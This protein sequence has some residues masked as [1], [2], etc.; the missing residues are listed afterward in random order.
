MTKAA[1]KSAAIATTAPSTTALAV[2]TRDEIAHLDGLD[3]VDDGLSELS[4]E[5][6]RIAAK[7]WNFKGVDRNGRKIAE[8]A[9]Y[10]TVDE[11]VSEQVDAVF[12]HM[13]KSR[14]Y[15]VFDNAEDKTR[16][17][18]RTYDPVST[19]A[20]VAEAIGTMEDGTTRPCQNCPDYKWR[21]GADGKRNQPCGEVWNVFA[22]DRASYTPFVLRFKRTALP[23]IK[24]YV[25]KHHWG[26]RVVKGKVMNYPLCTFAVAL[27]CKMSESGKYALPVL[28]RGNPLQ[29]EE[30]LSYVETLAALRGRASQYVAHVDAQAAVQASDGVVDAEGG[31]ASFEPEKYAADAGQDF[32]DAPKA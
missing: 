31:D 3:I 16:V 29:R 13:H 32:V 21:T 19:P 30:V 27:S 6:I 23:V 10:D 1:P 26:R 15:S 2:D 25:Q 7:V 5:D 14:V 12:L 20:E 22:I 8:D 11:T 18:C 28:Q 4:P 24:Q 9:F 17:V